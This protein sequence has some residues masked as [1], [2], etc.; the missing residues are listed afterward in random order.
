MRLHGCG[1]KPLRFQVSI[2]ADRDPAV[3]AKDAPTGASSSRARGRPRSAR[4][5][6]LASSFSLLVLQSGI[7]PAS[8]AYRAVALPLCY[9][10][11]NWCVRQ[12]LPLLPPPC[13]SGDLL[14]IYGRGMLIVITP[15]CLAH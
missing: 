6:L 13:Q 14:V 4:K 5:Q 10:S 1:G 12:V 15:G 8:T 9:K 11:V 3:T 7:E 2:G